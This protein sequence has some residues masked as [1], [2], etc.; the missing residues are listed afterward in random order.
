MKFFSKIVSKK[1]DGQTGEDF[2]TLYENLCKVISKSTNIPNDVVRHKNLTE[3]EDQ[4]QW[5]TEFIEKIRHAVSKSSLKKLKDINKSKVKSHTWE[6][7][8]TEECKNKAG[9][10]LELWHAKRKLGDIDS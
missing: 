6:V 10:E 4:L 3:L 8:T 7:Y 9:I 5:R 1:R 2:K